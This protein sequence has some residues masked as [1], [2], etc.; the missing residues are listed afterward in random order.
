MKR[1]MKYFYLISNDWG[2]V[3]EQEQEEFKQ[4]NNSNYDTKKLI[5]CW[6]LSADKF[7]RFPVS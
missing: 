4:A 2:Y 7:S 3:L 6:I 1:Q 5:K